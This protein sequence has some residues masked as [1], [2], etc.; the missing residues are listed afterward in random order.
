MVIPGETARFPI[1]MAENE[2]YKDDNTPFKEFTRNYTAL[3]AFGGALD[4]SRRGP[5]DVLKWHCRV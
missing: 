4:I 2:W 3:K 5:L 1:D